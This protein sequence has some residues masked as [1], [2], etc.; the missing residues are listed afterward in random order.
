MPAMK[1]EAA[2]AAPAA[3]APA[4][5][6]TMQP[7]RPPVAEKYI[8]MATE[9]AVRGLAHGWTMHHLGPGGRPL[10]GLCRAVGAIRCGHGHQN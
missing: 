2:V 1:S 9:A 6:V 5:I 8:K 7:K 3:S 10:P 4:E